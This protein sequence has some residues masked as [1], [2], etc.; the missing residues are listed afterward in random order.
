MYLICRVVLWEWSALVVVDDE[1]DA[2]DSS[3]VCRGTR[4]EVERVYAPGATTN[5]SCTRRGV[6]LRQGGGARVG[7]R[8]SG[9]GSVG[10]G[11]D[12]V[13]VRETTGVGRGVWAGEARHQYSKVAT[14]IWVGGGPALGV[15]QATLRWKL[16]IIAW[17]LR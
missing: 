5:D 13:A 2:V 16:E 14:R 17:D 10:S 12:V 8:V 4:V 9:R 11:R 1:E 6:S 15:R 7:W 3:K